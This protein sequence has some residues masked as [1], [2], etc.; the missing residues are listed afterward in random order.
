MAASVPPELAH[1]FWKTGATMCQYLAQCVLTP[2][3][4][5]MHFWVQRYTKFPCWT[6]SP[7]VSELPALYVVPEL[8]AVAP[9]DT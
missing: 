5:A 4:I 8:H 6:T 9:E 3:L 1:E 2:G 7:D